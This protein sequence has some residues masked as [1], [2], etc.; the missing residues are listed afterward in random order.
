[1]PNRVGSGLFVVDVASIVS[2]YHV[3]ERHFAVCGGDCAADPPSAEELERMIAA[4]LAR[5]GIA[6]PAAWGFKVGVTQGIRQ[7]LCPLSGA[8][9]NVLT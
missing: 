2:S 7:A 8:N 9:I 3:V 4:E 5:I 1:L 6:P